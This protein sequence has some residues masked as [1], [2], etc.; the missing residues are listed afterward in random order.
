MPS[1]RGSALAGVMRCY[2]DAAPPQ[3]FGGVAVVTLIGLM[4]LPD[5]F[6]TAVNMQRHDPIGWGL[7]LAL[8]VAYAGLVSLVLLGGG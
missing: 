5:R 6:G 7:A 3:P 1:L 4:T 2:D 8:G